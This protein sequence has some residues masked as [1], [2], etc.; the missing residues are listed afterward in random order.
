MR[1][2]KRIGR[3][4]VKRKN[5]KRKRVFRPHNKEKSEPGDLHI[6]WLGQ[7]KRIGNSAV[8]KKGKGRDDEVA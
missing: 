4:G 2:K 8:L 3:G 6:P 1:V 5:E 7:K